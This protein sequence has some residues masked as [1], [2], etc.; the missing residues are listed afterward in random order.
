M[1]K[2]AKMGRKMDLIAALMVELDRFVDDLPS[3]HDL[4]EV[5]E[6]LRGEILDNWQTT[7][8]LAALFARGGFILKVIACSGDK[9]GPMVQKLGGAV[10]GIKWNTETDKFTVPLT[11]NISKRRR[12][13]VTGP[14]LL[15]TTMDTMEGAVFTRRIQCH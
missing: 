3:G 11:V 8:T 4:R 12:G 7:G 1:K 13:E 9:E 2:I 6:K 5:I 10:L 14:D 15:R